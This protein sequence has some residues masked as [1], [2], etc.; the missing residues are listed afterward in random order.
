MRRKDFINK[1]GQAKYDDMLL[2]NKFRD[3]TIRLRVIL[4]LGDECTKCGFRDR[5]ALQIDHIDGSGY[6]LNKRYRNVFG[7][8]GGSSQKI[9]RDI[10]NGNV[11]NFQLLCANCNWI[12]RVEKQEWVS[13]KKRLSGAISTYGSYMDTDV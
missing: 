13:R 11:N 5:R 12:K 8:S 9:Y 3:D 2:R 10:L 4:K 6:R 1:Y 7:R